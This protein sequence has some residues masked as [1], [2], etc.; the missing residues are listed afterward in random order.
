MCVY[1]NNRF[2]N[3]AKVS[4]VQ[5]GAGWYGKMQAGAGWHKLVQAGAG[6]CRLVQA[7]TGK[8]RLVLVNASYQN[9]HFC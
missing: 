7:S 4:L 3:D 5:A 9:L 2:I 8:C 1:S 6:K